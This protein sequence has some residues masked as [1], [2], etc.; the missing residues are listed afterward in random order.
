MEVSILNNNGDLIW[1]S[2]EKGKG[3]EI[4]AMYYGYNEEEALVM[5]SIHALKDALRKINR[6]I[7]N[8]FARIN[9]GLQ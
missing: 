6:N 9:A 2:T 8:D 5:S 3:E 7:A 4:V 1:K